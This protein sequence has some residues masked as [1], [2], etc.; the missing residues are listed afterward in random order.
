MLWCTLGICIGSLGSLFFII[1]IN[2]LS[3]LLKVM[4]LILFADNS[5][6]FLSGNALTAIQKLVSYQCREPAKESKQHYGVLITV[7]GIRICHHS[8]AFTPILKDIVI[9]FAKLNIYSEDK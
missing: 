5:T 6:L 2:D 8:S 1:Y 3:K 4:S 9:V 7:R